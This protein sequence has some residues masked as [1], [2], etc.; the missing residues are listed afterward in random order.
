[1]TDWDA[2]LACVMCEAKQ[3]EACYT[4][5]ARGPHALPS[6]FADAP[7]SDRKMRG[8]SRKARAVTATRVRTAGSVPQRRAAR[9]AATKATGWAAVAEQQRNR[10]E[11]T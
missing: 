8:E 7:H 11:T 3:G 2:Y 6:R 5:L 10:R 4:L 9:K 1:M